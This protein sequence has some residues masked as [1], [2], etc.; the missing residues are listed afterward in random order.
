MLEKMFNM[1]K[2]E[3]DNIIESQ[4]NLKDLSNNELTGYMD[5]L[6]SEFTLIKENIVNQTHYL[7]LVKML[8]DK[9]LDEYKKRQ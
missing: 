5:K 6:S 4:K 8:Y 2:K 9:I 3:L 7:D 1:D